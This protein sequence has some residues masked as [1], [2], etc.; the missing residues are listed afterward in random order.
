MC[1]PNARAVIEAAGTDIDLSA[2]ALPFMG[3]RMGRWRVSARLAR[4]GYRRTEFEINVPV[5]HGLALWE[6]LM[7]AET[8]DITPIGS[9]PSMVMRC[10]F[11]GRW[12]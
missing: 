12:L 9:E 11:R 5:R 7:L 3:I 4:V 10:E 6:A 1:G 8:Y 2:E